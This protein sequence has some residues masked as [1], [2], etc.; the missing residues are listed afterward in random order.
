MDAAL[1]IWIV[2]AGQVTAAEPVRIADQPAFGGF[3][4]FETTGIYPIRLEALRVG[5]S[6]LASAE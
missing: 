6:M 4:S 1:L 2:L 3:L 5:N